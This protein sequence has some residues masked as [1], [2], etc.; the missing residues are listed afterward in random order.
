MAIWA[1]VQLIIN[2]PINIAAAFG[3][4]GL[5][6]GKYLWYNLTY[7][8]QIVDATLQFSEEGLLYGFAV[9][10]F[11]AEFFA[12]D[13]EGFVLLLQDNIWGIAGA[14]LFWPIYVAWIM[15]KWLFGI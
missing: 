4:L 7:I 10:F 15:F 1:C 13:Y 6:I 12:N 5:N 11:Y 2:E 9:L 8:W 3:V 14:V